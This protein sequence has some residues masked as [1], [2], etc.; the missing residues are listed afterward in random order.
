MNTIK[1]AFAFTS[2]LNVFFSTTTL[3]KFHNQFFSMLYW[4]LM[5]LHYL[6]WIWIHDHSH[7]HTTILIVKSKQENPLYY[8][9]F[10]FQSISS[11]YYTIVTVLYILNKNIPSQWYALKVNLTVSKDFCFQIWP[12]LILKN[13]G[14]KLTR[15]FVF[16][17]Y[18]QWS[19][20]YLIVFLQH[21]KLTV[22][23][24]RI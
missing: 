14:I 18:T 10:S 21:S 9:Q 16:T 22:L 6:I 3:Y 24:F 8:I 1:I 15:Y 13:F 2:F 11:L 23:L 7:S 20:L 17:V 19:M 5:L 4:M 12:F